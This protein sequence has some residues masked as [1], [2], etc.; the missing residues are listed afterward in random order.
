MILSPIK[1]IRNKIYNFLCENIISEKIY[2]LFHGDSMIPPKSM[3]AYVGRV[4]DFEKHSILYKNYF[5]EFAQLEKNAKVLDVGCGIGRNAVSLTNY[6]NTG[7][8]YGIDI[9][10]SGIDWCN[11]RISRKYPNFKFI[12]SDISNKHYNKNGSISASEYKFPFEDETFDFVFLISVFTHLLPE[13][14]D[15]YMKEISRVLKHKGNCFITFFIIN[16]ES[17]RRMEGPKSRYNFKFHGNGYFCTKAHDPEAAI[18]YEEDYIV[19]LFESNGMSINNHIN[20]GSWCGRDNYT[21]FQDIVV[22]TKN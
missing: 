13:D 8:Y 12:H 15:N 17:K 19:T 6:L 16:N 11:E 1:R 2:L 3:A 22:A 5:I 18:A 9:V 7:S 14:M 20:Y 4:A 10:K 21:D